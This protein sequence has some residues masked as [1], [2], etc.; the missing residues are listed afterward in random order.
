MSNLVSLEECKVEDLLNDID[1]SFKDY[2][3]S[4][5]ALEFASFINQVADEENET[6]I[7]HLA[8]MD[9][10]FNMR[11][12]NAILCF[13]GSGKSVLFSEYLALYKGAFN[14][15]PG[16]GKTNLSIFVGDSI[17]NGVKNL[18][19]NVEHKY[20]NSE[21]LQ[22]LIPNRKI[23]GIT[24]DEKIVEGSKFIDE[25]SQGGYKFT[26]VRF[27][28]KN[29][30]GGIHITKCYGKMCLALDE[31]V[32][33]KDKIIEIQDVQ[34]GDHILDPD[35]GFTKVLTKS[36]IHSDK[37]M[38]KLFFK[39]GREL[40]V[41]HDHINPLYSRN[42]KKMINITTE[43]LV[44]RKLYNSNDQR[45][46]Y[47][48]VSP[49][50]ANFSEKELSIDPY[51]LGLLLGDGALGNTGTGVHING[52]KSDIE[53]FEEYIT[54]DMGKSNIY[55]S[56]NNIDI[57]RIS[58]LNITEELED[59]N[60][61][62]KRSHN[63]FVPQQYK[64]GS[65]EQRL[66]LLRGYMD[67]DG[68]IAKTGS[69]SITSTSYKL[70]EDF[71]E[72][73]RSLGGIS[74][75][76]KKIEPG[77]GHYGNKDIYHFTFR[78][79]LNPF[80]LKRKAK[81]FKKYKEKQ[82]VALVKI[83]EVPLEKSI[84]IAVDHK[85]HLFV[86]TNYMTTHNTGVRG[87]KELGQR[88]TDAVFDDLIKDNDEA[89]S[90]VILQS[91]KNT[92]YKDVMYA[93]HP[94]RN[95][96]I[97]L[98]TPYNKNDPLY[99]AVESGSWT[100]AVFPVCKDFHCDR[101]DFKGAWEDRF[102]YDTVTNMYD[103]DKSDRSSFY[104]EVMLRIVDKTGLLLEEEDIRWY[105]DTNIIDL[106]K[107][108]YNF[109]I[110]TDF[111]VSSKTS[112][113][114]STMILWA[115]DDNNKIYY[116]NGFMKKVTIDKTIDF[117]F[118]MVEEYSPMEVGIEK[119]GQ[120]GGLI[121]LIEKDMMRRGI[122]FNI[123]RDKGKKDRGFVSSVDKVTRFTSV[124]PMFKLGRI[125]F[126]KNL[127]NSEMLKVGLEQI[128]LI[129]SKGYAS[130][131]DDF[132][133]CVAMLGQMHLIKPSIEKAKQIEKPKSRLEQIFDESDLFDEDTPSV[134]SSYLN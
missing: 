83:E 15:I 124:V 57:K 125:N 110:T 61:R 27:E 94:T 29:R 129:S 91:I 47:F 66:D 89:R 97:W 121:T 28:F 85:D 120:Q 38:Y 19:R 65:I 88:P 103:S 45:H 9:E 39:D 108:R 2:T 98:G 106:N 60:L 18:R 87:V 20:S 63:K 117:L 43:E 44:K 51:T 42:S 62:G 119:S 37:K 11:P 75:K 113:D 31:K 58:I 50:P 130:R 34:V 30:S 41:T 59:L 55:K 16:F 3:P 7:F 71:Q 67:T 81:R 112:A 96:M 56:K 64:I 69:T 127:K 13:R 6:P 76:I 5:E 24:A 116:V 95:K 102:T 122:F 33:L 25:A 74:Y 100:R 22:W 115:L 70:L 101:E 8:M 131:H 4:R 104:Q 12:R 82:R 93:L 72:I 80:K 35:G 133:D 78:I 68:S 107:D 99:Q 17:E 111:A 86:T 128:E 79:E 132:G 54:E 73:I 46:Y 40:R 90:K 134:I 26:D 36:E 52:N 109:Y 53:E 1:Y 118:E 105:D 126:P 92:V 32:F 23:I 84:C 10:V 114:Y 48:T 14:K 49:K 21:Y 123:G 77:D